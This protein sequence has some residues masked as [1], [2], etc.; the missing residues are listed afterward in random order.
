MLDIEYEIEGQEKSPK[1]KGGVVFFVVVLIIIVIIA[2]GSA[3]YYYLGPCGEIVVQNAFDDIDL[4]ID[5]YLD[6]VAIA[7]QTPRMSLS[8][9]IA[10]L[11]EI[12]R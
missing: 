10:D 9:P 12:K 2:G 8:G 1:K 4:V 11:Q 6:A 3:Y 5:K 7:D